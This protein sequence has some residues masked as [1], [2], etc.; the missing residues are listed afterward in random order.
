MKKNVLAVLRKRRGYT[1]GELAIECRKHEGGEHLLAAN[2][3]AYLS[4][5]RP[6]GDRHFEILCAVL[7][8]KPEDVQTSR[9]LVGRP[10]DSVEEVESV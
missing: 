3:C 7:R 8:V 6:I 2:L 9:Y 1:Y 5:K 4:G 10:K